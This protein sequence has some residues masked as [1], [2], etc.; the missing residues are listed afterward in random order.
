M[1]KKTITEYTILVNTITY[2]A[3]FDICH[4][5]GDYSTALSEFERRS[6]L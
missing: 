4:R 3:T 2:L 5:V 1:S 6:Q